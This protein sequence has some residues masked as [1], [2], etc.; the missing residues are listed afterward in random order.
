[1]L[2]LN[3]GDTYLGALCCN[4]E[5]FLPQKDLG[6]EIPSNQINRSELRFNALFR[7][8]RVAQASSFGDDLTLR[9]SVR[10]TWVLEPPQA[11]ELARRFS[12]AGWRLPWSILYISSQRLPL[13]PLQ[14]HVELK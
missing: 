3:V 10:V 11:A 4:E 5:P 2:L 12:K 6:S 13:L 1:M 9:F 7:W 8:L 14:F